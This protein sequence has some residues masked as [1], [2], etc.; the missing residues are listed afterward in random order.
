MQPEQPWRFP[1]KSI[2]LNFS[3]PAIPMPKFLMQMASRANTPSTAIW[4]GRSLPPPTTGRACPGPGLP[5]N[6][7]RMCSPAGPKVSLIDVELS[8]CW[9]NPTASLCQAP[10]PCLGDAGCHCPCCRAT[11]TG[12]QSM[13]QA[14]FRDQGMP[15][16]AG[17][18][19]STQQAR[20]AERGGSSILIPCCCTPDPNRMDRKALPRLPAQPHL[21]SPHT[22]LRHGK[23][24]QISA[25][26]GPGAA[27]AQLQLTLQPPVLSS[28]RR[29]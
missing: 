2:I 4:Q 7:T 26:L 28:R 20:W 6:M 16:V 8:R 1:N 23:G 29:R 25:R 3:C 13:S 27:R 15:V 9:T 17:L 10:L 19:L 5:T 12:E 22:G 11:C 18:F 21:C 14:V 24:P